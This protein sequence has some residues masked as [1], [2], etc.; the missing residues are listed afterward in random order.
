VQAYLT[1][2]GNCAEAFAF[3]AKALDGKI[4]FSMTFG[5]SPMAADTPKELHGRIMHA[6]LEAH[7]LTIMGSDA[8]PG[9]ANEGFKGFSLSVQG[10]SVEDGQR[11]FAALGAGGQVTMPFAPTFWAKG[12]G[13]L[14]DKFGVPW[15]VNCE[16]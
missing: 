6:T 5:D 3:Y 11:L 4:G 14:V 7:G 1:F 8:M 16:H 13:M 10:K 15:M 9:M 2:N 12:F